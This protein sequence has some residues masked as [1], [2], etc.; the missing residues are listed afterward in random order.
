MMMLSFIKAVYTGDWQ[1]HLL[2][3]E[4]FTKYFFAHDKI[5]YAGMIPVYLA[6]MAALKETN[7]TIHQEFTNGNWVVNKNKDVSFC[8]VGGGNA[9]EH[10]NRS[11]KVLC[12]RM[13]KVFPHS[14]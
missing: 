9:L 6:E 10:Q 7:P 13:N 12:Q 3:L 4:L 1:L 2:S 11:M 5:N 14:S 8:A